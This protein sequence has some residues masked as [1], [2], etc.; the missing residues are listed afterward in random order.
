[1]FDAP[2]DAWYLWV[3]VA[4]ASTVAFGVATTL[5][6]APPPDAASVADTVDSVAASDR[7][8]TAVHP[9]SADA[10]RVGSYRIWLR[11]D[12]ETGHATVTYGPVT[13][14][15]RGTALW[16]VL[17][18]APPE[19]AFGDTAALRRAAANAENRTPEWRTTDELTVRT[20]S[21][22]GV[23]VTLVG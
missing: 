15:R 21:W 22:E 18:G 23:D 3:G 4:V 11:D 16:D 20:I 2:V 8:A 17:R 9:L 10:I 5:P 6:R 14:V 19:T 12:G 7:P 1:M 13:P